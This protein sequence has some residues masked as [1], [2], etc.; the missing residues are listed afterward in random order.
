ML[1][2]TIIHQVKYTRAVEQNTTDWV[3]YKQQKFI[4]YSS[5]GWKSEIR[6]SSWSGEGSLPSF[7]LLIVSLHGRRG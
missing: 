6:V 4:A 5:G 2:L 3:V 1:C 7:R